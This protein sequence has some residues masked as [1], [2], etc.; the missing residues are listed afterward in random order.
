MASPVQRFLRER[1]FEMSLMTWRLVCVTLRAIN[2]SKMLSFLSAFAHLGNPLWPQFNSHWRRVPPTPYVSCTKAKSRNLHG[3]IVF[4]AVSLLC[5][6]C[7]LLKL[8][9]RSLTS[10]LVTNMEWSLFAISRFSTCIMLNRHT[11][12]L[13]LLAGSLIKS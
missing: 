1:S 2:P 5:E 8:L 12:S 7:S 3:A 13:M 10:W 4:T 6:K 9:R 11:P